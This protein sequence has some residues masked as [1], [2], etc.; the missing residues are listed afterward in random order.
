[1]P[2]A[3]DAPAPPGP[4]DPA[5]WVQHPCATCGEPAYARFCARCALAKGW[6]GYYVGMCRWGGPGGCDQPAGG[7]PDPYPTYLCPGHSAIVG[8]VGAS[9]YNRT[10]VRPKAPKASPVTV[11]YVEPAPR[12]KPLSPTP[13]APKPPRVCRTDGCETTVKP[14]FWFC[15]AHREDRNPPPPVCVNSGCDRRSARRGVRCPACATEHRLALAR[16]ASKPN[17]CAARGC[18]ERTSGERCRQHEMERRRKTA[19]APT[20]TGGSARL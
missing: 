8:R 16:A 13:K 4:D 14:P 10:F 6:T 7:G 18:A 5:A 2:E 17:T 1:V 3:P 20:E 9:R 12:P 15:A 11:R 19:Y